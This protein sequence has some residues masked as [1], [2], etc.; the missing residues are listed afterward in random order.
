VKDLAFAL[1]KP[2]GNEAGTTKRERT[3]ADGFGGATVVAAS[4]E[5]GLLEAIASIT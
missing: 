3:V 2:E 1:D 4:T 5:A